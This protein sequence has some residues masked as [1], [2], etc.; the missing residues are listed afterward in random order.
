MYIKRILIAG[1]LLFNE[2]MN[3]YFIRDTNNGID[4]L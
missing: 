1:H 4:N 2:E 3:K